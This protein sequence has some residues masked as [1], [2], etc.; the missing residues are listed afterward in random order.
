[1]IAKSGYNERLFQGGLRGWLHNGRFIWLRRICEGMGLDTSEVVELGCFDARS[2]AYLPSEPIVYCGYDSNWEGGLDV[3]KEKFR[4]ITGYSFYEIHDYSGIQPGDTKF[5]LGLCLE[6]LEHV[7]PELVGGYLYKISQ[8][9]DGMFVVTVPNEKGLLLLA[10]YILKRI[11]YGQND[12]YTPVEVFNAVMGRLEKVSRNEHKGFDWEK[13]LL[14][15]RKYFD[16]ILV[17]GVQ[18]PWAPLSMNA[19]I[20]FVLRTRNPVADAF[21]TATDGC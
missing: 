12:G 2:I 6:T 4:A 8:M 14:E 16:V 11:L 3:A 21:T 1:V 20:G 5:K 7:K 15:L 10:K 18:F 13:L 19:Q 9:L 17:Q